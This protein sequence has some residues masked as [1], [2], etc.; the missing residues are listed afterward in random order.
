VLQPNAVQ[1]DQCPA[2]AN[3]FRVTGGYVVPVTFGG[4][5]TSASITL[6]N[7]PEFDIVENLKC[8]VIHPGQEVWT[9]C[10]YRLKGSKLNLKVPLQRGCA[11]VRIMV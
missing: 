9:P 7:L 1:V 8:E 5:A 4:S 11:M 3:L 2:K 6:Q 10:S